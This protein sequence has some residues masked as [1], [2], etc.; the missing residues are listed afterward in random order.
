MIR[1]LFEK[2]SSRGGSE[3]S[4]KKKMRRKEIKHEE[5]QY[6]QVGDHGP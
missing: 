5:P 1:S 3:N 6:P 2:D 4:A